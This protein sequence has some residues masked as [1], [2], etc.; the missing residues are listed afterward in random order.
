[1]KK[2]N[3]ISCITAVF[4]L[5]FLQAAYS[6]VGNIENLGPNVNSSEGDNGPVI[7]PD[8]KDLYFWSTRSGSYSYVSHFVDG[9]WTPAQGIDGIVKLKNNP[10]VGAIS[11]TGST[12]YITNE[13]S[14][15]GGMSITVYEVNK[16]LTGWGEPK[17]LDI[18]NLHNNFTNQ[19]SKKI[20][21]NP[22]GQVMFLA[23]YPDGKSSGK[24]NIYVSFREATGIWS[25]PAPIS[26]NVNLADVDEITPYLAAD[27]K[28]LYFSRNKVSNS[29]DYDVYYCNRLDETYLKW[30]DPVRLESEVNDER[31]N[32]GF[33][34]DALGEFA[35]IASSKNPLKGSYT[36]IVRVR[37]KESERPKPVVLVYGKVLN[38]KTK[39]PIDQA[40]VIYHNL[41]TGKL[42]GWITSEPGTG[43]YKI[44]LPFGDF[45]SFEA[46]ANG[47]ISKTDNLNLDLDNNATYQ[48]INRDLYLYPIEVGTNIIL[49]NI[50]F[51][52][53][54]ATL[55]PESN[56]ELD[57]LVGSMQENA[58]MEIEVSGHTDNVGTDEI[59]LKL[60]QERASA[61]Q[62]Y[63]I[64]SKIA[65][66]RV[67]S[68]GYGKTKPV[69][70]NDTDENRQ[71]N[72]RVEFTI[73]KK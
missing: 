63:L 54:K 5:I 45:Y 71:K 31:W 9:K 52:F 55:R 6:Q 49:N 62:K 15:G 18:K 8:G 7:S 27:G 47:Y 70:P 23:L 68:K 33:T 51:D 28:T 69:A 53:G 66:N 73:L 11:P 1:M 12:L 41:A 17:T 4:S 44:V 29:Q 48:E 30:S 58:S 32:V 22:N 21:L 61:V 38:A 64:D 42:A 59:N 67:K 24:T 39:Q 43:N 10:V 56:L 2:Q 14:N 60:S 3:F 25:E 36:D 13:F 50:F 65:S 37:L 19:S 72:R 34:I 16:T 20:C 35:Y 40:S 46:K 57:K 26:A